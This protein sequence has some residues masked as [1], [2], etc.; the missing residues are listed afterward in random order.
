MN[1][2]LLLEPES[3]E[4]QIGKQAMEDNK[5]L[6]KKHDARPVCF[7]CHD[8]CASM[9]HWERNQ[10]GRSKSLDFYTERYHGRCTLRFQRRDVYP[11]MGWR[12]QHK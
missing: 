3:T 6:T 8:V 11:F 1:G 7:S 5:T 10:Q 9:E 4:D 12:H 2:K